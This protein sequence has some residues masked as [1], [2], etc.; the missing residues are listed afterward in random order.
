VVQ[1]VKDP[2]LVLA[3]MVRLNPWPGNFC[4]WWAWPKKEEEEEK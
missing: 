1:W 4:M 2:V 3:T